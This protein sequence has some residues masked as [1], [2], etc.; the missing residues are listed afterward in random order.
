MTI[1]PTAFTEWCNEVFGGEI[2]E[3]ADVKGCK[4]TIKKLG[5]DSYQIDL[6]VNGDKIFIPANAANGNVKNRVIVSSA[7]RETLTKAGYGLD[8]Y[9]ILVG[10]PLAVSYVKTGDDRI[11]LETMTIN[12][13]K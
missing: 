8:D 1:D 2:A 6:A 13:Q 10:A 12:L 7:N 5:E 3:A 9:S 4:T 11:M